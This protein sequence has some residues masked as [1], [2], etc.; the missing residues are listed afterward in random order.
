MGEKWTNEEPA[1]KVLEEIRARGAML[2]EELT[3]AGDDSL[4]LLGDLRDRQIQ[5]IQDVIEAISDD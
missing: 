2:I 4:Q 3:L 5:Y 1:E